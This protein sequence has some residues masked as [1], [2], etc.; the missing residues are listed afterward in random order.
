MMVSTSSTLAILLKTDF[1]VVT[2]DS[3]AA[4]MDVFGQREIDILLTDQKMPASGVHLLEWV[5][6]HYPKTVRLL[7]TASP[8]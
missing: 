8:S 7:M 6:Q 2:A 5:K 3:A 4:A 1:D